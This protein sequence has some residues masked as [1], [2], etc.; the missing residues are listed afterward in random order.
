[1]SVR[2]CRWLQMNVVYVISVSSINL[3]TVSCSVHF[4]FAPIIVLCVWKEQNCVTHMRLWNYVPN[5]L[6]RLMN[7]YVLPD[8]H[9]VLLL[10]VKSITEWKR[11]YR[12]F[13]ACVQN[14]TL[15]SYV[16]AASGPLFKICNQMLFVK[17][18]KWMNCGNIKDI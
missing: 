5:L 17:R 12:V 8:L 3:S 2:T 1:M 16:T 15:N 14:Y 9:R 10:K 13:M 4:L 7:C 18:L 6:Y 11:G